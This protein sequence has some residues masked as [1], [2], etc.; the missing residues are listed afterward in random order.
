[1]SAK[2]SIPGAG[3]NNLAAASRVD[4]VFDLE[5]RCAV[6][7]GDQVSVFSNSLESEGLTA[8]EGYPRTIASVF[9]DL[10]EGFDEGFDAGLTDDDGTIHLFRDQ[11]VA[12]RNKDLKWD[13]SPIGQ[14]WGLVNNVLQETGRVDAA[15]AGLDGKIYLFSGDQY[16]RYSGADLSRID[17]GYPKAI[18]VPGAGS[19]G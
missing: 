13:T 18:R 12:T 6:A 10:P 1:L 19:P 8:D 14:R 15:F 16:V 9:P 7:V 5:G 17:E 2:S 11:K 3:A 4:A